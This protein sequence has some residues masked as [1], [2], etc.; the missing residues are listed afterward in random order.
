MKFILAVS[1][2]NVIGVG[3]KLPWHIPHDLK[4]FKM[5]TYNKTIVMGRKTYESMPKL[6]NRTYCVVSRNNPYVEIPDSICIGGAQLVQSIIK[7]GDIIYLTHV[8]VHIDD[9]TSIHICLPEKTL[10]WRTKTFYAKL[11]YYFAAYRIK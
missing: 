1:E 2:N 10:L 5:N 6:K 7:S 4:W 9:P 11:D 3:N 8:L